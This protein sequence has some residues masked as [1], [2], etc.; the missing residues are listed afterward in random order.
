MNTFQLGQSDLFYSEVFGLPQYARRNPV[1][2][3]Q[4]PTNNPGSKVQL[5]IRRGLRLNAVLKVLKTMVKVRCAMG[6]D[7]ERWVTR[8]DRVADKDY[9]IL[10]RAGAEADEEHKMLTAN[11]VVEKGIK[12]M[13]LLER[14][15]LE[16]FSLWTS[17]FPLDAINTTTLCAGSRHEGGCP[18]GVGWYYTD[19]ED[20]EKFALHIGW[21]GPDNPLTSLRIREVLQ[22]DY[23]IPQS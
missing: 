17:G 19:N 2:F 3:L 8:H 10:I 21:C 14:L 18:T 13:T 20:G 7:I 15:V 16:A 23:C 9:A 22:D 1:L 11:Q 6:N 5:A 12:N 4:L